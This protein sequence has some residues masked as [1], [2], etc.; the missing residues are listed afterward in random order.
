[1]TRHRASGDEV[2][3]ASVSAACPCPVCGAT[4]GCSAAESERIVRCQATVSALPV[5]GGGWLHVLSSSSQDAARRSRRVQR[6]SAGAEWRIGD[7]GLTGARPDALGP[8][9]PLQ[10]APRIL[11]HGDVLDLAGTRMTFLAK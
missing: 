2:Q 9:S 3:W 4:G 7:R 10:D 5:Q 8:V 11:A 6:P 1:M